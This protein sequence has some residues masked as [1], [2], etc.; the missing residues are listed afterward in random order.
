MGLSGYTLWKVSGITHEMEVIRDDELPAMRDIT[1][2]TEKQL[3]Q[4]ILFERAMRAK[5]VTIEHEKYLQI[6]KPWT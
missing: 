6:R 4:A 5:G 3:E 1:V 2:L